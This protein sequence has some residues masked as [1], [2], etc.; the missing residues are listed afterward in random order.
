FEDSARRQLGAGIE[1]LVRAR[2]LGPFR[3]TLVETWQSA[4]N[5]DRARVRQRQPVAS[6]GADEQGERQGLARSN[7]FVRRRRRARPARRLEHYGRRRLEV[8]DQT[9]RGV[10]PRADRRLG[11]GH[12]LPNANTL[13]WAAR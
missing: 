4:E 6:R 3:A 8:A 1:E 5:T 13:G 11:E 10:R 9:G 2:R 12:T 7:D